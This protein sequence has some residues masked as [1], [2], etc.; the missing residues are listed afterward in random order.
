MGGDWER[1]NILAYAVASL[2]GQ[3]QPALPVLV[4]EL[5]VVRVQEVLELEAGL[6]S[7]NPAVL[8]AFDDFA[9]RLD[10]QRLDTSTM[11]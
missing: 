3:C 11:R 1:A 2:D 8:E 6:G 4:A 5:R 9:Q 10:Q 7:G